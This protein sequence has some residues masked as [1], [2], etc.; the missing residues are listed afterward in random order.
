MDEILKNLKDP[1]VILGFV[2]QVVYTMRFLVQ[3]IASERAK[4]S[5]IPLSF[6]YISLAGASLLLAYA[7]YKKDPVFILGQ[8]F[9][10]LVYTRNL[11][12]IGRKPAQDQKA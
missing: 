6:W 8:M 5:V 11:V 9:G 7:I 3:W 12:L 1:W 10:F 2:G 4:R